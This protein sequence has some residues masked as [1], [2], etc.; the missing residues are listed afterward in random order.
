LGRIRYS[1]QSYTEAGWSF[2]HLLLG[3]VLHIF[4]TTTPAGFADVINWGRNTVPGFLQY[5]AGKE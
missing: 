5:R 3:I 4:L 2:H 1:F